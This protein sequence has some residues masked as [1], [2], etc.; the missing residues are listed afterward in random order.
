MKEDKWLG[1]RNFLFNCQIIISWVSIITWSI[2][3][4]LMSDGIL[5]MINDWNTWTYLIVPVNFAIIMCWSYR[6][7]VLGKPVF[8]GMKENV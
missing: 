7:I 6:A 2:T 8:F 4:A 1:L 5:P 3:S